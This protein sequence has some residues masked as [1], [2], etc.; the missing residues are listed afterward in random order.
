MEYP[1]LFILYP[2]QAYDDMV[3]Y[4]CDSFN[5]CRLL[6]AVR[7]TCLYVAGTF[8]LVLHDEFVRFSK[9]FGIQTNSDVF[10]AELVYFA[11]R[12]IVLIWFSYLF[13]LD[14]QLMSPN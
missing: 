8:W 3:I 5:A 1:L 7:S 4:L 9:L 2:Y 10:A 14:M 13:V 11:L 6:H 12:K